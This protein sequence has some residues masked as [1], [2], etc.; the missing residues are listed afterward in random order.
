MYNAQPMTTRTKLLWVAALYFAEGF[1]L[2]LVSDFLPVYF[3]QHSISL[4]EI[5]LL[6]LIGLPWTLK[7]LWAPAIDLWGERKRW[8]IVC[9]IGVALSLLALSQFDPARMSPALWALL[10]CLP[11][12][13]ATQDIA[14]DAYTIELMQPH[15][16]GRAN[17][18]RMAAYRVALMSMGGLLAVAGWMGWTAGFVIGALCMVLTAVICARA[19]DR[20]TGR[21]RTPSSLG[22]KEQAVEVTVG[23]FRQFLAR[24]GFLFVM[25]FI[26]LF[27]LGDMAM[28]PMIKPFWVDRGFTPAQIGLVSVTIG[29][30]MTTLGAL[31]GGFLTDRWGIFKALWILGLAQ[32]GSNLLYAVAASVPTSV[33]LIYSASILESFT[34]GLGTGPFLAFLMSICDKRHAATQYALLSALFGFTRVVSGS[35]SGFGADQMGYSAYF[36]LT[37][38]LAFPAYLLLPWLKP[39][40]QSKPQNKP[41]NQ[42]ISQ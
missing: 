21:V 30:G 28:G 3:R 24:P 36:L 39:W 34:G 12:F 14:I 35:V 26:L 2:G 16:M 22:L 32:A 37:F 15:E 9:Q 13:S 11:L 25:L 18:V 1:P 17:G 20:L 5:G 31:L 27:K 19:D 6:S 41:Q 29:V 23:A 42:I 40:T 38:F 10:L 7:F 33:P 8:M 4:K